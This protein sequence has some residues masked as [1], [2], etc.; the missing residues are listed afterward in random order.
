M[1][2]WAIILIHELGHMYLAHKLGLK[3]ISIHLHL[4]HGECHHES[5]EYNYENYI[6]AWGG[7]LAQAVVFVPAIT[8]F[9]LWGAHFHWL[10]NIPLI[11][12]GYLSAM[13]GVLS[14]APYEGYDGEHCWKAIPLYLKYTRTKKPKKK[15]AF[16]IVK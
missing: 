8:V 7:F 9:T 5:S 4:I 6:V 3:V 14:L 16:K 15:A 11:F 2:F 12:L 13:I 1:S 10:I